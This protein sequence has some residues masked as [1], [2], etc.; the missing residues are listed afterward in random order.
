MANILR[1]RVLTGDVLAVKQA[2]GK[3]DD[4]PTIA[5]TVHLDG[6]DMHQVVSGATAIP[7][8]R[9]RAGS[10]IGLESM[11]ENR[12]EAGDLVSN[13]VRLEPALGRPIQEVYEGVHDGPILGKGVMGI[14]RLITH[15][16]TGLKYAVK[17]LDL[18]QI[19]TPKEL[20]QLRE[21]VFIMCKLHHP[22]IVRLEEVY[23]SNAEIYLV[24][25][26]CVGRDL[27]DR[28]D[29]Q[30]DYRYTEGECARMVKQICSAVRYLHSKGII[31]RDLK[32]E[33][34]LFSTTEKDSE[35]KM[36]DFGLSKHFAIG[37]KHSEVVGTPYSVAPE[38]FLGNYD[39]RCDLW[40]VG[41]I[42]FLLLSGEV[43]TLETRAHSFCG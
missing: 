35:L 14:V 18:T 36:C 28:L 33:N 2:N 41:V 31:H 22:N 39:E 27:L 26:L 19:G 37:E 7:K 12:K 42:T 24:M 43:R 11:I 3:S 34:F 23:E 15:R 30:P 6:N 32:L 17:C 4:D 13:V 16:V 1:H 21:E 38:V 40:A 9:S 5:I 20:Q 29:E 10:A 8:L 25:E